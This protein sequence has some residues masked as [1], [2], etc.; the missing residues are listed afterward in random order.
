MEKKAY[1]NVMVSDQEIVEQF[2][3]E[4]TTI[5]DMVEMLIKHYD[6]KRADF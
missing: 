4:D 2:D 6:K 3:L 1:E 5:D